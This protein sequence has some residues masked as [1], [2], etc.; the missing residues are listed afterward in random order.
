M[1]PLVLLLLAAIAIA[2]LPWW[3]AGA[4]VKQ[5]SS[6]ATLGSATVIASDKTGTLT[7]AEMTLQRL[8]TLSG[9]TQITGLGYAPVGQAQPF[10]RWRAGRA[11]PAPA[12]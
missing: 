2:G 12:A 1:D 7:R 5:L 10:G 11:A 9:I 8:V 6:M 4:V 3:M